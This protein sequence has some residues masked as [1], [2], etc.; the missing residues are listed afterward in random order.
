M[1]FIANACSILNLARIIFTESADAATPVMGRSG[2]AVTQT[3]EKLFEISEI[4]E[5]STGLSGNPP[6]FHTPLTNLQV[7]IKIR[8]YLNLLD[9][10]VKPISYLNKYEN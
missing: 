5:T 4:T 9:N 8:P 3:T 1:V 6:K 2:I 7:S 10:K